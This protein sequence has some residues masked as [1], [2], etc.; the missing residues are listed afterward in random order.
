MNNKPQ[1]ADLIK[2]MGMETEADA[3]DFAAIATAAH[4]QSIVKPRADKA[5]GKE[6]LTALVVGGHDVSAIVAAM[7][8]DALGNEVMDTLIV[9]G[10]DWNDDLTKTILGGLVAKGGAIT[11]AVADELIA[12]SITVTSPAAD[13]GVS[14]DAT[15]TDFEVA[16]IVHKA[17]ENT[18][19]G[20]TAANGVYNTSIADEKATLDAAKTA[21]SEAVS[22][23]EAIRQPSVSKHN[24]VHAW[25]QVGEFVTAAEWQA[26]VDSL[27]ASPDGNGSHGA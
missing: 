21:Y 3:G 9:S 25:L 4:S 23:A 26:E 5:G 13:A 27:L 8:A 18:T 2:T 17:T 12:L 11:Q 14:A 1:L 19:A 22:D 7:R 24:A 20:M 6:S 10:V 15:A 16:W